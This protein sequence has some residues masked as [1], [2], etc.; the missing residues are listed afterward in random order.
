MELS[1]IDKF[2]ERIKNTLSTLADLLRDIDEERE[3]DRKEFNRRITTLEYA[4]ARIL[5]EK[6]N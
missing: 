5:E 4:Y 1:E 2:I 6:N 3:R